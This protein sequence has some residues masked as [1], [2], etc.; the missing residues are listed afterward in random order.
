MK[1]QLTVETICNGNWPQLICF[2]LDGT[3]VDSAPSITYAID[4]S[5]KEFGIKPAGLNQVRHWIG[6]GSSHLI[7]K[8]QEWA[9]LEDKNYKALYDAFLKHYQKNLVI[10]ATLY[11]N[12]EYI[13]KTL[14]EQNIYLALITNKPSAFVKPL[15]DHFGLSHYFHLMLG[16]DTLT[17]KKP[18]PLPIT[19][20][21]DYFNVHPDNALMVGDS[22]TDFQAASSAGIKSALVT[23]G[24][25]NNTN[26]EELDADLLIDDLLKLITAKN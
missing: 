24:Y 21:L 4:S 20:C 2:D 14:S 17:E 3:L 22:I 15:M 23:Y 13:L 11:S 9:K 26:L 16:G 19:H 25:H 8:T 10:N 18:S 6:L 12:V 7:K 1:N 5:L